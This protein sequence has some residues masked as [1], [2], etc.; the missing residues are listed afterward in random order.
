MDNRAE[1][2]GAAW[3]LETTRDQPRGR[4]SPEHD[5]VPREPDVSQVGFYQTMMVSVTHQVSRATVSR[6]AV[7]H[8]SG[9]V[10]KVF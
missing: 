10:V 7:K 8:Q 3:T 2:Q 6:L 4:V 9:T 1:P 5:K